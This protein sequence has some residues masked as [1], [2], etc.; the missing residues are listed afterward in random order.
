MKL[1]FL[2]AA[3]MVTGSCTLL[4]HNDS[5]ILIDCGMFQGRDH[6]LVQ[7]LP[8]D[9]ADI[10]VVL[11]T[12]SHI[13]HSG[14]IPMLTKNGFKGVIY[15]TSAT[16]R[17]A[18]LLL[19]DSAHIQQTELNWK[20]KKLI[21]A[22]KKPQEPLYDEMDVKETMKLFTS[23]DY[24]ETVSIADG[25]SVCFY[26]AGHL[27]GSSIVC[28][29]LIDE[30]SKKRRLVFSGDL[31]ND[32]RPLLCDPDH[33]TDADCVIMESTYGGRIH[34]G[35][36]NTKEELAR[37]VKETYSRGGKVIIPAFAVGRTQELLYHLR[38]LYDEGAFKGYERCPVFVDSPLAVEATKLFEEYADSYFD[39]ETR[40]VLRRGDDP[41]T[42]DQLTLSV[43]TAQ[44]REINGYKG[45]CIIISASGMCDAGRIKHHLKY[46]LFNSNN[47]VVFAGYQAEGTLGR[48]LL[49]GARKVNIFG[50]TVSV[51]AKITKISGISAHADQKALVKWISN[52][53]PTPSNVFLNHGDSDATGAL[54]ALVQKEI[55]VKPFLPVVGDS[56]ELDFSGA[57]QRK[58]SEKVEPLTEVVDYTDVKITAESALLKL[59]AVAGK[60][61]SLTELDPKGEQPDIEKAA[62]KIDEL[63]E[64]LKQNDR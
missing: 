22:G 27:L 3:G 7:T 61:H 20:N 8:C 6:E 59:Y 25:I 23:A 45:S 56:F 49:E 13:D 42:F 39:E 9:A 41:I 14:H 62:K 53:A 28:V 60:L 19:M 44:S 26:D 18:E 17:L 63:W 43:T 38:E 24:R 16:R 51:K 30:D 37:L 31:G 52:F 29:E 55:G 46:N 10:D 15:A 54:S 47:T 11:L 21:R 40:S 48:R 12:H 4:E 1:T 34:E 58:E 2:G 35:L 50:E 36:D 5:K 32:S 33:V 57:S 64:L